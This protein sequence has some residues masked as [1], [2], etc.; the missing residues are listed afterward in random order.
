MCGVNDWNSFKQEPTSSVAE[1]KATLLGLGL[2][3]L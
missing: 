2:Q 1:L 3:V